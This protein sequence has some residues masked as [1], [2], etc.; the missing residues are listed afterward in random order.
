M[1][2]VNFSLLKSSEEEEENPIIPVAVRKKTRED[3]T[4][5]LTKGKKKYKNQQL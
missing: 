1:E 2:I 3:P 5:R 4:Q